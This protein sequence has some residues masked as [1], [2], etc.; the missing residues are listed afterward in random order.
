LKSRGDVFNPKYTGRLAVMSDRLV[1]WKCGASLA[2]LPRPLSRLAECP[3]CRAYLHVCRLCEF[4][5]P[6]R[7]GKCREERAEEVRDKE[8]ANFCDWFKPRPDAHRLPGMEKSQ[9]ARAGMEALFGGDTA[10]PGAKPDASR[11]KLDELFGGK[12]SSDK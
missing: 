12:E 10:G 9:A 8:H 6:R 3:K 7:P 1:C 2:E 4:Y 11:G 5:D